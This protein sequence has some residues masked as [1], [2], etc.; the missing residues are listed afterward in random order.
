MA[1]PYLIGKFA[2]FLIT[3]SMGLETGILY[4]VGVVLSAVVY[5]L[6]NTWAF[7]PF[8]RLGMRGQ[9]L[10]QQRSVH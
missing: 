3:P 1:Q 4:G 2:L 10:P 7:Y 6:S 9:G 8:Q 5:V